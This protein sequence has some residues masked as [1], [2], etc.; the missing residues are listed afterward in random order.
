MS[1]S[2]EKDSTVLMDIARQIDNRILAVFVD[3]WLEYPQIRSL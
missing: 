2:G 1:F 3:T